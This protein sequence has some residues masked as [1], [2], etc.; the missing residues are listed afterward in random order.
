MTQ[1]SKA[2]FPWKIYRDARGWP[3]W[4]QR[5]Y[6]AFLVLTGRY[7]FW[8]AWDQGRHSGSRDEYRRIVINGGD[9]IPVL[10][11]AIYATASE[12]LSGQKP[13]ADV[14]RALRAKAWQRYVQ[15]RTQQRDAYLALGRSA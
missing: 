6:E 10:D 5:G 3:R 15:Q 8:H 7:T 4:W 14:L 2:G 1:S 9:L 13:Q 11:A 12:I